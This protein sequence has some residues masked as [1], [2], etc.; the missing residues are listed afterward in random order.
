LEKIGDHNHSET[1]RQTVR[2]VEIEDRDAQRR[3]DSPVMA[4]PASGRCIRVA[5]DRQ[6]QQWLLAIGPDITAAALKERERLARENEDI[7][8]L[9]CAHNLLIER[10]ERL[11]AE[12]QTLRDEARKS[13]NLIGA[14]VSELVGPVQPLS[15]TYTFQCE[16]EA[17]DAGLAA[18]TDEDRVDRLLAVRGAAQGPIRETERGRWGDVNLL[19]FINV[20]PGPG[21]G[22]D[23]IGSAEWLDD[24]F[25]TCEP[26]ARRD[27]DEE[28]HRPRDR[29]DLA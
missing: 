17:T 9:Q 21:D 12:A 6:K 26:T 19:R 18:L 29:R 20:V 5:R 11:E 4:P 3:L 10:A 16:D 1:F 22:W 7:Q 13:R 8:T 15:E 23:K 14:A 24:I 27:D 2:R 25:R 28:A